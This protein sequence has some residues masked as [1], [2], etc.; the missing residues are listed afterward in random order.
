MNCNTCFRV[1]EN[2]YFA[3]EASAMIGGIALAN[4]TATTQTE[5]GQMAL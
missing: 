2:T 3:F 5:R 4:D 1:H